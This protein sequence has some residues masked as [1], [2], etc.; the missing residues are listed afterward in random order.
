[1]S[2]RDRPSE[3]TASALLLRVLVFGAMELGLAPPELAQAAGIPAE[4]LAPDVLA[5]PD[6]R[7]P[8]SILIRLWEFLPERAENES[9]GLWLADKVAGAP[10]S[11]AWWVIQS[12]ATLGEGLTRALRYQRLLHDAARSELVMRDDVAIYRHQIGAPPFRPP[13][14]A[15]EFGFASI[16]GLA[17]RVT[18]RTGWPRQVR[19][20]HAAPRDVTLHRK[21]LGPNLSF[22]QPADE[23]EFEQS[24]LSLP[25]QTADEGLR[26]VVEAHARELMGRLPAST[27]ARERV[28]GVVCE[29]LRSGPVEID[30]VARR[31]GT[32]SRTL[33]RRL[34]EEGT[35]FS[36][37]VDAVRR[38]LSLRYLAD[39]R[40]SIQEA[41]FLLAFSDVSAFHRAFFRWTGET[42]S[43]FRARS[44][45]GP[46]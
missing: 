31:L 30:A 22:E 27:T 16:V 25:L 33:Q 6:A 44:L 39:A 21:L 12:S 28:R 8:A 13:H 45:G 38:E 20:Q 14:H 10:L 19:L 18:G 32:P 37:L 4:L 42:P 17:Q 23:L 40:I 41:A 43:R 15:I 35:S 29:L 36:E 24:L 2:G 1:M 34:R 7:V 3:G 11:V 9:Y 26:E 46:S 5:D